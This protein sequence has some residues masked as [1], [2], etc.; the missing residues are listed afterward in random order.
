MAAIEDQL[1]RALSAF[2]E[3]R[4]ALLF[5]SRASG[6]PR[7][8]SDI[9][10][11][12]LADSPLAPERRACIIEAVALATGCPI[13]LVDLYH[14]PEPVLGEALKGVRLLGNAA[15]HAQLVTRHVLNAADFL[16]LRERILTERRSAWIG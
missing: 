9:D 6:R 11:A 5:G 2:P 12:I 7:A 3:I 4:L 10:L 13:D 8:D 16:P 14:A 15:A 1:L